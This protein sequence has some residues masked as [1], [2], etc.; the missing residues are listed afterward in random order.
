ML[1]RDC[2]TSRVCRGT[3]STPEAFKPWASAWDTGRDTRGQQGGLGTR[4]SPSRARAQCWAQT[5]Q[6]PRPTFRFS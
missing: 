3:L 5:T 1:T 4:L 6:A 2:D